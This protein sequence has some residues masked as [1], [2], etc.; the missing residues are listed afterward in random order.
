MLL[1]LFHPY[2]ARISENVGNIII[3]GGL[4]PRILIDYDDI[5]QKLMIQSCAP[6]EKK[7]NLFVSSKNTHLVKII[8]TKRRFFFF[9]LLS[10]DFVKI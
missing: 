2:S 4:L 6:R 8:R 7:Y 1:F 10:L 9:F 5:F 3:G